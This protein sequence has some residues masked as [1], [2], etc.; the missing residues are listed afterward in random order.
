[1]TPPQSA[2]DD[3]RAH[4]L[5]HHTP[6]CDG[7]P[8]QSRHCQNRQ[9]DEAAQ[10]AAAGTNSTSPRLP[11]W[12]KGG[13]WPARNEGPRFGEL[14]ANCDR[15]LLAA[16]CL[17]RS[18]VAAAAS[19]L[20]VVGEDLFENRFGASADK[21]YFRGHRGLVVVAVAFQLVVRKHSFPVLPNL[22]PC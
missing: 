5:G 12:N 20:E 14:S 3:A 19:F 2:R 6:G 11:T 1:M 15:P 8:G 7:E 22:D 10:N 21:R 17:K 13:R 18:V 9:E 4:E 16:T